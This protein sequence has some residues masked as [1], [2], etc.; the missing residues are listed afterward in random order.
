MDFLSITLK[1]RISRLLNIIFGLFFSV[2][3]LLIAF[4]S[5]VP[6][7]AFYVFLAL[8]ESLTTIAIKKRQLIK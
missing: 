7:R 8:T 2:I 6:W 5:L 4:S 1:P 3:M